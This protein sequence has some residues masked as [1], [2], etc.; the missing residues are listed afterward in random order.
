[1]VLPSTLDPF[2]QELKDFLGKGKEIIS[3]VKS[4]T[5]DLQMS[6]RDSGLARESTVTPRFNKC[7]GRRAAVLFLTIQK[8]NL[9]LL[10]D[11]RHKLR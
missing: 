6:A 5:K 10:I 11:R 7:F 2:W 9:P 8:K 4:L 1:M 3:V